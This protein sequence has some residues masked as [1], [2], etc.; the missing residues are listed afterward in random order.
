M[1][2]FARLLKFALIASLGVVSAR[3][4][5]LTIY[6]DNALDS[7]WENWSWSTDFNFAATDIVSSGTTSLSATSGAWAAFS[8]RLSQGTFGGYAGLRFDIAGA[9][10]EIQVYFES[11]TEGVTS[12][13]IP[14]TS[15]SN[16]VT[17]DKFTPILIDFKTLPGSGTSLPSASWDRVNI[18]ALGNGASYHID[19][20]VFVESIVITPEFLSAEPIGNNIIAVTS[21]GEVDFSTL[22]VTLGGKKLQVTGKT[23]YNPIDTPAKII[24]Y[25][26]LKSNLKPGDLVITA[27][28]TT[29][30]YK[31]PS[32]SR[33][34]VVTSRN[35]P[36]N[37]HVYGINFPTDGNY[38]KNLGVTI[39]RWGGNAVTAY[40]PFGGFTNAGNDWYFE[41]RASDS[42]DDWVGWV[43]DAGADSLLT[44][45]SLDWVSK[46]ATS[47]SYPQSIYPEQARY[48]PYNADAG[49]G[50]F[51]NGSWVAAPDPSRIYT[52]WNTS[53]AKTWLS[54]L[55]HKPK[56]VNI[57]NEIEIAS[58]THQDMHPDPI[59]YDEELERVVNFATAAKEA[60]PD[61]LVAAPSSCSWW[62][63][64]TSSIGWDDTN[65]H[66][67]TD[68][69]PWFLQQ[70]RQHDRKS[71]KRLLDYL[72]IH[73]YFQADTSANDDAAKALRLRS[74]RSLWDPTYVDESWI[75]QDPQ[76]HQPK[77]DTVQLIPRIKS[78]ISQYYPGTKFSIGEWS[79]NAPE[80]E[81]TG[82]LFAADVLGI[83]G[84]YGV[85]SATYWAT[86][87]EQSPVGLAYWLYRGYGT[88][89][90]DNSA[91][92]TLANPRPDVL[93][94]YAA[95]GK[96]GP[97]FE[98]AT[99]GKQVLSLVA[100]NKSGNETVAF[101]LAGVP[102]G[103]YFLRHFGA[104][105]GPAKWQSNITISS[106]SYIVIPPH[107][108][109]FLQQQ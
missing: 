71:G 6:T 23:S 14:L 45:P 91:Q 21:K 66:N 16:T 35:H 75:G 17:A 86:P 2:N 11:T 96:A 72:D 31:L 65:A 64:W 48:D 104:G 82:G 15:I 85:D 52:A 30:S 26:T 51:A 20:F 46:D 24:T 40:N 93:G 99:H 83:W 8:L 25:L 42:A 70:M 101:D 54:G 19:N 12:P 79:S 4:D 74:T 49:N 106:S 22:S 81:L 87:G 92:V 29:F 18:Q 76:N 98:A 95:V 13:S 60:L 90:G 103:K 9:Q 105:A 53:A 1:S 50:Q 58:S 109:A 38:I 55:T 10:P 28:E 7:G 34:S 57:D 37:P 68:F 89:F 43:H 36:I 108:A 39:A 41:N 44:I 3:A 80:D 102:T 61:V 107:T 62:F 97:A 88:Y 56:L 5:D 100:I 94:L 78:L 63:Y 47:Y 84:K 67:G 32:V 73:Y 33:G 27:G 59:S 77:P 69:L